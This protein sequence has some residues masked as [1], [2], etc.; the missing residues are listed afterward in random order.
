MGVVS[1]FEDWLDRGNAVSAVIKITGVSIAGACLLTGIV[2]TPFMIYSSHNATALQKRYDDLDQRPTRV[3][4][5]VAGC[6]A[7][8]FAQA[9]CEQSQR[10]AL[11]IAGTMG[12]SAVY[13]SKSDCEQKH[14]ACRGDT[15]T[16]YSVIIVGQVP[17]MTPITTTTYSA[18]VVAWQAAA[19]NLEPA[20][21]LYP[22]TT[23]G[24]A[25]RLLDGK[26]F[27]LN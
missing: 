22:S 15:V 19:D 24:V 1:A 9:Q 23:P 27:N 13:N 20:V 12:T 26:R 6:A 3:F 7:S 4:N 14:G 8:G 18:P 2:A 21:P 11:D 16:T 10:A 17:V 25:M 5:S